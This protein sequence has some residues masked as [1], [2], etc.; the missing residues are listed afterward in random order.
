MRLQ[1]SGI[2]IEAVIVR[3]TILVRM[4]TLAGFNNLEKQ[5]ANH[6]MDGASILF[7]AKGIFATTATS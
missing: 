2:T 5:Y 1:H 6:H 3:I 7:R 4:I